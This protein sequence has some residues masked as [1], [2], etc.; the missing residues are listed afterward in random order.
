[1]TDIKSEKIVANFKKR[2]SATVVSLILVIV[3]GVIDSFTSKIVPTIVGMIEDYWDPPT[4]TV[5]L[6]EPVQLDKDG[7]QIRKASA[8]PNANTPSKYDM[9]S[10]KILI[11]HI[12]PGSYIITLRRTSGEHVE[13][14]NAPLRFEKSGDS[15]DLK[16]QPSDWS[17]P[18]TL[19][20][21]IFESIPQ[22]DGQPTSPGSLTGTRWT[23]TGD[24]F[25]VLASVT[26]N[27]DRSLLGLSL[28]EVGVYEDGSAADK[29]RIKSYWQ[30]VPSWSTNTDGVSWGG[31][32][33]SWVASNAGIPSPQ[34]AAFTAWL[35]W[36]S[37][38]NRDRAK[39]GMLAI[40]Q[41]SDIPEAPSHLLVGVILRIQPDCIEVIAGNV[42]NH[43]SISC[44]KGKVL[45]VRVPPRRV[46][47]E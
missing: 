8:D 34:S 2:P 16:L 31:T 35:H 14:A 17:S 37:S 10:P 26:D 46:A 12:A 29:A 19:T 43:V 25:A 47:L 7:V 36:G 20:T 40:F 23:T 30:S 1:M 24:D 38:V 9:I 44:V 33:L 4:V 39:P 15:V 11:V 18:A 45:D 27:V 32:F 42:A 3:F 22:T 5:N 21:G 6:P 13:L 28:L 41:R